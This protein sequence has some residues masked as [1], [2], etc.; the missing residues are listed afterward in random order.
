MNL[1]LLSVD[2]LV[3]PTQARLRDERRVQHILNIHKAGV[4]DQLKVGLING[5]IGTASITAI[6][7][8]EIELAVDLQHAPPAPLP[9]TLV[10]ALPRGDRMRGAVRL[11]RMQLALPVGLVQLQ[12]DMPADG[13]RPGRYLPRGHRLRRHRGPLRLCD[14]ALHRSLHEQVDAD[15]DRR[16]ARALLP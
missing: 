8:G 10:L 7:P 3:S 9:L 12:R 1:I 15:A 5:L 6:Y 2:D 16:D 11:R 14:E 13:V 4:D